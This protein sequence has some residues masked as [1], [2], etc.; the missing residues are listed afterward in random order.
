MSESIQGVG[1]AVE[2]LGQIPMLPSEG[3]EAAEAH[4]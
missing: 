2:P 3:F 1:F 4:T